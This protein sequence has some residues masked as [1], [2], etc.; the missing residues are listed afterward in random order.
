MIYR[1]PY[2][3]T[4]RHIYNQIKTNT[5]I[6]FEKMLNNLK[7]VS[8]TNYCKALVCFLVIFYLFFSGG[9]S[10]ILFIVNVFKVLTLLLGLQFGH[11]PVCLVTT[12]G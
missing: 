1:T 2:T 5:Y 7:Q 10:R 8:S 11:V 4:C 9:S 3:Y 6:C 12:N